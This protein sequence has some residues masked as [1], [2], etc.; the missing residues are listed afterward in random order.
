L[1]KSLRQSLWLDN[2]EGAAMPGSHAEEIVVD[3]LE[4]EEWTEQLTETEAERDLDL[5]PLP[6]PRA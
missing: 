5:P 1:A 6:P 3:F 2:P 4:S